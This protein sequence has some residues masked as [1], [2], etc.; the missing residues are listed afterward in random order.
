MM[1]PTDAG[2]GVHGGN[3]AFARAR[4]GTPPA[5]WLDLSTG[6]NPTPYPA[7]P[8]DPAGLAALPDSDALEALIATA[9]EA[10]RVPPEANLV[11]VPGSE[12]AIRLLPF[13]LPDAQVAIFEPTYGSYRDAWVA[14]Q[15]AVATI[16]TLEQVP[17]GGVNVVIANPNNPDG[18]TLPR[19]DVARFAA[20]LA[21]NGG[22]LVVDEAFADLHPD[23]SLMPRLD[24]APAVVLRSFGKFFG[25]AGLRLGFVAGPSAVVARLG[26]LLGAW[27][28]SNAAI[29]IGRTALSDRAWQRAARTRLA[30]TAGRLRLLLE[31]HGLGIT[32][33]TDLFVLVEHASAAR[34]HAHLAQA[35]IWTRVFPYRRDWL[36]FGLPSGEAAFARLESALTRAADTLARS[37]D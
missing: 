21:D 35:G 11:A 13:V 6:I 12:I 33:G 29:A 28:L 17:P 15:R 30:A 18:R 5:G 26:H 2:A 25:M 23:V 9:R 22:M 4:Y 7:E 37:E 34:L 24:H 1:C 10:Y 16:E 3:L 19:T 32:G 31:Q 8:I 14:S 36:R 20:K 27:P